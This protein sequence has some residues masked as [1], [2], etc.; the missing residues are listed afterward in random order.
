MTVETH[1][2]HH[3]VYSVHTKRGAGDDAPK[4]LRVDYKIGWN[5][6]KSEWVCLEHGGYARGKAVAWWK[7]RSRLP[8][9]TTA[10]D[11]VERAKAGALAETKSITVRSVSGD[12]YDRITDYKLGEIPEPIGLSASDDS[13]P[14]DFPFGYNA[15]SSTTTEEEIPW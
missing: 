3:V 14:L 13:D 2:V 7:R 8:M 12:E 5:R 6:W 15:V 1:A 9:P 4:S 11:A 10:A